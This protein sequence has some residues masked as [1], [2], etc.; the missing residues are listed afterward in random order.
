M[1]DFAPKDRLLLERLEFDADAT[2]A[3]DA[4]KGCLVWPDERPDGLS[5]E[6][7]GILCDLWAARGMMHVGETP[8]ESYRET[9]ERARRT[10]RWPGFQRIQL[11]EE[12]RRYLE[13]EL[14]ELMNSE[15]GI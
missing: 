1:K 6:G 13:A 2:P 7:Y 15:D 4:V 3:F 5:S 8:P 14:M 12:D 9:W 11:S 10:L